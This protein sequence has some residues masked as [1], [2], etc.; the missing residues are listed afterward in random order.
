MLTSVDDPQEFSWSAS[1]YP[2]RQETDPAP[3]CQ[4]ISMLS[5]TVK[6]AVADA[7][8]ILIGHN[9]HPSCQGMSSHTSPCVWGKP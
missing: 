1:V 3:L 7:H 6:D 4:I 8:L 2:V 9:M 5:H